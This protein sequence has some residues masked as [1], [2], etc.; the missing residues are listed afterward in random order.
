[1]TPEHYN[2]SIQPIEYMR[3]ALTLEEYRGFLKGNIIKYISRAEAK[4]GI[5]DYKK[6]FVYVEWLVKSYE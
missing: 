4:G 5:E 3:V 6:A 2:K 1:M